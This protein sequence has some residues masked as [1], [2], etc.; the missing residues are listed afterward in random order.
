MVNFDKQFTS[1]NTSAG[2][3]PT[4]T[5][6]DFELITVSIVA[7][8]QDD[9]NYYQDYLDEVIEELLPDGIPQI[10]WELV[11][12]GDQDSVKNPETQESPIDAYERA[13]K[14]I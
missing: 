4:R 1:T 10:D 5:V 12:W 2:I 3:E 14:G 7:T 9:D 13:M 8:P 6:L 11:D